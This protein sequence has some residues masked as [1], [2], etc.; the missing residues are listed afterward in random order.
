MSDA[1]AA[2]PPDI[3]PYQT[4]FDP[5]GEGEHW[6]V[7]E[8]LAEKGKKYLVKWAGIDKS[9]GKPWP[10]SW[11]FKKDT[12]DDLI[13]EWKRKQEAEKRRKAGA[14]LSFLWTRLW[15]LTVAQAPPTREPPQPPPRLRSV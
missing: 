6:E 12:T 1:E 10:N 5:D 4:Q 11:V 8:I 2:S 9:T 13:L 3:E 15:R 14:S 7:V